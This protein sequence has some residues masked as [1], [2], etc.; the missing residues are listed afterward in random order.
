LAAG[1][2]NGVRFTCAAQ[3]SEAVGW[4]RV[5]GGILSTTP[6]SLEGDQ[7]TGFVVS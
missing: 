2:P 4:K 5:L 7:K 6:T 3:R 1:P